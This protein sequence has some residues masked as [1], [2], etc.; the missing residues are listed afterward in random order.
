MSSKPSHIAYV[1]VD[2]E[3]GSDRKTQWHPVGAI[4]SHSKGNGF[5]LVIPPGVTLSGR[6]VCTPRKEPDAE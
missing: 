3:E 4:W 2:P 6:I 5:D 1:V